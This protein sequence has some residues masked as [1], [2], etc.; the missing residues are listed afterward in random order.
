MVLRRLELPA[1]RS[2]LDEVIGVTN[3][4]SSN[5]S[6]TQGRPTTGG[7]NGE[8]ANEGEQGGQK[9][10]SGQESA[11]SHGLGLQAIAEQGRPSDKSALE[12]DLIGRLE[13]TRNVRC[14]RAEVMALDIVNVI[15]SRTSGEGFSCRAPTLEALQL[16]F[17]S[18]VVWT[19]CREN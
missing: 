16:K 9:A 3:C 5:R 17:A 11:K 12:E 8:R 10:E 15:D 4:Y 2:K 6:A 13:V 7:N 19:N 14:D 18:W 1:W